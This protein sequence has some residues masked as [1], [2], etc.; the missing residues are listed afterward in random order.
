MNPGNSVLLTDAYQLTMVKG[1]FDRGMEETA[2]FEFYVRRLPAQRN[3]LVAAGLEQC[4]EYLENLHFSADELDWLGKHF[5]YDQKFLDY[6]NAL[7]FTGDVVALPEG[8][9]FFANEP[10]IRLVA[11]LPLVQLVESRIINLLQYQTMVASKAARCVLMGPGKSL[12]DFGMRRAHGA[13]ASLLS[14]RASY[15]AGFTGT[16]TVLAGKAFGIPVSGT[17][18]HSFVQS[19]DSEIEA[20]RD[21]AKS[22]P[23]NAVFLID[24][25]D[26]AN[27][28]RIVVKLA[29]ELKAQGITVKAVRLDSG[30]LAEHAR[31]VRKI[32]DAGGLPDVR[33]LASGNLDEYALE[34]LAG[35]P[36]DGYGIGTRMNTSNDAPYFECAYKLQEYKGVPRRKHSEGKSTWPG[37][38]QVYRHYDPAG[39]MME[40]VMTLESDVLPGKAL[41]VPVMR[42]GKRVNP[43]EP[44][45]ALR[46]RTERE[47]AALPDI[48]KKLEPALSYKVKI[49][50][51]LQKLADEMDAALSSKADSR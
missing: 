36:I 16:A 35:A 45:D 1:Y 28:A 13:E 46:A 10:M 11:P 50:P 37:R 14:S 6:L 15:I 44:L 49:S 43:P 31:Q 33:I 25:Y 18:A 21:F 42:Q 23:D 29:P 30:D 12:V 19:H 4:L 9:V 47:L 5:G 2:V 38:K 40:D 8:T 51:T 22:N 20:F 7:K 41:M 34:K 27:G 17:M 39:K 26:T 3:F 32:L 48:L 24:T